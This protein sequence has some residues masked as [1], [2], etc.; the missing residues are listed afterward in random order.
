LIEFATEF[1][2]DLYKRYEADS[3]HKNKG[4]YLPYLNMTLTAFLTLPSK[5]YKR[6]IVSLER[7]NRFIKGTDKLYEKLK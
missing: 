7:Y 2:R 3:Y 5:L 1:S 4:E 6:N